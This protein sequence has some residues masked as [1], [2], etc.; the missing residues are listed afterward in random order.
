[1]MLGL[2]GGT[3]DRARAAVDLYR[4]AGERAGHEPSVLRVGLATHLLVAADRSSALAAYPN[5]LDFLAPK[6]PGTPGFT[7]DRAT[8]EAG[9][10]PSGVLMIGSTE[11]VTEKALR[12]RDLLGADRI[13]SLADWGGLAPRRVEDSIARFARH[14]AP[15]LRKDSL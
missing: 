11:E 8:Y 15:A 3:I 13:L 2:I 4:A 10:S 6:R 7:V 12:L 9:M 1:M 14:V 5:Y